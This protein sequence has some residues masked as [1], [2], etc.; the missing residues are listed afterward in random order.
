VICRS[1]KPVVLFFFLLLIVF[2][3]FFSFF[4]SIPLMSTNRD[5][6]LELL[7]SNIMEHGGV[8]EKV[9]G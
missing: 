2:S 4:L 6:Q 1:S 9:E 8:E 7:R 3:L 5:N